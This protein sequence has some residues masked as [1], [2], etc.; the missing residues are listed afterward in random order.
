M[1]KCLLV[2]ACLLVA[3]DDPEDAALSGEPDGANEPSAVGAVWE[4]TEDTGED[5]EGLVTSHWT[6]YA[7]NDYEAGQLLGAV[8]D[9]D[10]EVF[11]LDDDSYEDGAEHYAG[12]CYYYCESQCFGGQW[13]T[14]C[15]LVS[16]GSSC[17]LM[18]I[19]YSEP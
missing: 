10:G 5:A 15:V 17:A 12:G 9:P 8:L 2:L 16:G 13:Y 19:Y 18:R 3:C 6:E 4:N 7:G 14:K 1:R 11:D